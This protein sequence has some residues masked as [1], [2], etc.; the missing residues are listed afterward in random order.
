MDRSCA[1]LGLSPKARHFEK[2][3]K[4]TTCRESVE[5]LSGKPTMA[6]GKP[7]GSCPVFLM[8][9]ARE[10]GGAVQGVGTWVSSLGN[11]RPRPKPLR[12]AT[13]LHGLRRKHDPANMARRGGFRCGTR[14]PSPSVTCKHHRGSPREGGWPNG[15][16]AAAH[17]GA[18]EGRAGGAPAGERPRG[19][20]GG[21]RTWWGMR[22]VHLRGQE[23]L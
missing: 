4:R 3:R 17:A 13:S 22:W 6:E 1:L 9:C 8:R 12:N 5:Q 10:G 21:W 11:G 18:P 2:K 15:G 7:G 23:A 19:D 20:V 14:R 16:R